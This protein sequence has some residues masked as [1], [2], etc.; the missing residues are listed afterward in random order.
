MVR[1]VQPMYSVSPRATVLRRVRAGLGSCKRNMKPQSR[2]WV[3]KPASAY[4]LYVKI[5]S[6]SL[7]T[8]YDKEINGWYNFNRSGGIEY[9]G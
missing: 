2:F 3:K 7:G 5:I 1:V 6:H 9:S 8:F 4:R